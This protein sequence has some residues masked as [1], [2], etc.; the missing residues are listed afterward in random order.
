[1]VATGD[2]ITRGFDANG[3]CLLRDCPQLSW[4]TGT[5][6]SVNSHYTR[7][8]ALNPSIAGHQYNV[9]KTGAKMADLPNQMYA[10]GYFKID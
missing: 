8:L 4:S 1:M 6:T 9:A 7:I 10:A 2:S 3:A 5:D